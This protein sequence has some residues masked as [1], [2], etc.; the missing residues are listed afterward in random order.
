MAVSERGEFWCENERK[1]VVK[2]MCYGFGGEREMH[3]CIYM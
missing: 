1:E 3:V 2:C